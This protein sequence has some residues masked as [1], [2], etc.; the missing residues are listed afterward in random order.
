MADLNGDHIADIVGVAVP[1]PTTGM[2]SYTRV[3]FGSPTGMLT[4]VTAMPYP[5]CPGSTGAAGA[6]AAGT[7]GSGGAGTGV[8][9][10][11]G[12]GGAAGAAGAGGAAG[13]A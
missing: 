1:S 7:G 13:A 2:P 9:G 11:T 6:G 10:T 12:S 5:E 4:P 3:F 8:A